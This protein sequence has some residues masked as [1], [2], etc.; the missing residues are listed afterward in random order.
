[1]LCQYNDGDKTSI[2]VIEYGG[3]SLNNTES[4]YSSSEL[5]LL[6][7]IFALRKCKLYLSNVPVKIFTDNKALTFLHTTKHTNNRLYRWSIEL[8]NFDYEIIYHKGKTNPV[9]YLSRIQYENED[10]DTIIQDCR[11]LF[12]DKQVGVM[13]RA[14]TNNTDIPIADR[15]SSAESIIDN[16]DQM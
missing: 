16:P 9:D 1:M 2:S 5:E 7:I 4:R 10:L 14:Q 6:A 15:A 3:R 11:Y 8:E 12:T 13:T